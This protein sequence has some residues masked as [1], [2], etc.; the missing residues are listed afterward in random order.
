MRLIIAGS[1]RGVTYDDLI[2]AIAIIH[3]WDGMMAEHFEGQKITQV[4]CGGADGADLLGKAWADR[5]GVPVRML[6]ADWE[7]I[8]APGAVIMHHADGK[9]Y[10]AKADLD[11]NQLMVDIAHAA[12]FIRKSGKSSGTDD[13]IR[14]AKKKGIPYYV[15][16]V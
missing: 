15:H 13:C 14:R 4:I 3:G 11:R 6:E 7:D 16:Q 8:K 9:P 2:E 10:N 1:R 12:V 5:H